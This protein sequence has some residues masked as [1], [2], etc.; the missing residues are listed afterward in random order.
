MRGSYGDQTSDK[1]LT[2]ILGCKTNKNPFK[3]IKMSKFREIL[4][5]DRRYDTFDLNKKNST[6]YWIFHFEKLQKLKQSLK[7]KKLG[8]KEVKLCL[9]KRFLLLKY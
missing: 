8:Q 3:D 7:H 1:H 5:G 9:K 2:N 4:T 6:L